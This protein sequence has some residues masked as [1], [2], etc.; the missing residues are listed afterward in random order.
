MV[1]TPSQTRA[2]YRRIA[3]RYDRLVGLFRLA[4][5]HVSTYRRRTVEALSVS[6]GDTVVDLGCGTG[7]N[8]PWLERAVTSSGLIDAVRRGPE[9]PR[10]FRRLF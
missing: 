1:L 6:P 10:V 9:P 4:G 8:F 7:R 5:A 3:P 2:L